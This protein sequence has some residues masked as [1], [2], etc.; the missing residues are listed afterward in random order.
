MLYLKR[1]LK[2]IL[3]NLYR[4][5]TSTLYYIMWIKSIKYTYIELG[6]PN[7]LNRVGQKLLYDVSCD[8]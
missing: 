6:L 7:S 3:N 8:I 5:C 1:A 2:N 4:C